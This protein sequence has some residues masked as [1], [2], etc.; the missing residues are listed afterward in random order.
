MS[1]MKMSIFA[2]VALQGSSVAGLAVGLHQPFDEGFQV[3]IAAPGFMVA[4]PAIKAD[5]GGRIVQKLKRAVAKAVVHR[6]KPCL[7]YTSRCV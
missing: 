6:Q 4:Q 3:F 1:R 5:L 2:T 7:L